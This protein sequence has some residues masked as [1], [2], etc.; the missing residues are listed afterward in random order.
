MRFA[1]LLFVASRLPAEPA[2]QYGR[3]V[4]RGAPVTFRV[5]NGRAI[6]DSDIDLGPAGELDAPAGS[7]ASIYLT[8]PLGRWPNGA[9]P[10]VVDPDVPTPQR[11][12]DA[13]SMWNSLTPIRLAP[14]AGEANYLRFKREQ[15]SGV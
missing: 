9:I 7:R 12:L 11:I 6:F 14:R 8:S 3:G 2:E 4:F 10:Y 15:N 1:L 5:L 13:A